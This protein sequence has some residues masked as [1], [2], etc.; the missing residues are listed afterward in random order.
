MMLPALLLVNPIISP[1]TWQLICLNKTASLS[2]RQPCHQQNKKGTTVT[3]PRDKNSK[4]DPD[5]PHLDST[6]SYK[7]R[8]PKDISI[9]S[10]Q[11]L[12]F[13]CVFRGYN[14]NKLL[15]SKFRK[16][17]NITPQ[18]GGVCSVGWWSRDI[19]I[20]YKSQK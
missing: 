4:R 5:F 15:H 18:Y 17:C 14:A 7:V 6:H 3:I 13:Y 11:Y 20:N 12:F 8:L 16:F 2:E 9:W 1:E 10:A 19:R